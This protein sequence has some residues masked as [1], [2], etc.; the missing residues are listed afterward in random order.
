MLKCIKSI[1]F[2]Y[3]N[4]FNLCNFP[5]LFY[6]ILIKFYSYPFAGADVLGIVDT[7]GKDGKVH[8]S[9]DGHMPN[10]ARVVKVLVTLLVSMTIGAVVLMA[11]GHNP[12]SA[13]PFSLLSYQN[14]DHVK[15]AI[16]SRAP[17]AMDKWKSIEI[18]YSNTQSGNINQL[19]ALNKL[20]NPNDLNFHFCLCNGNGGGNGE[21]QPTEIWQKQWSAIPNQTWRGN[22]G[23][24]RICIVADTQTTFP[25]DSQIKRIQVLLEGLC[26]KF[27]ISPNA[28]Y[29]PS[30]WR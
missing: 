30:D 20:A 3:F 15:N 5:L 6:E 16:L 11:L 12:P 17:Q 1:P 26:K 10:Q 2:R 29:Y 25:T 24:I 19:A 27:R 22:S 8:D 7:L 14:L 23:T 13:G 4:Q 9:R 28:I 18:H 21:I